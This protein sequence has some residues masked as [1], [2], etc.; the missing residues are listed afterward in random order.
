MGKR[1]QKIFDEFFFHRV[2]TFEYFGESCPIKNNIFKAITKN[3]HWVNKS[4]AIRNSE[5]SLLQLIQLL[6]SCSHLQ[7][8]NLNNDCKITN[9]NFNLKEID[10]F[11]INH[12]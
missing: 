6:H 12:K 2:E 7:E 10:P 1:Y 8:L 9:I 11:R 5:V 3:F 4:V